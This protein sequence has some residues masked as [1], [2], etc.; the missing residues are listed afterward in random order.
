MHRD[1]CGLVLAAGAGRRLASITGHTP[2]QYWTHDG[3]ESLLESTLRRLAPVVPASRTCAVVDRTHRRFLRAP[4]R[5]PRCAAVAFQPGDRGTAAGVL[6][7]LVQLVE[8]YGAHAIVV[9]TP[10]DHGIRRDDLFRDGLERAIADVRRGAEDIVLFGVAPDSASCDYGWIRPGLTPAPWR[11]LTSVEGFV[12]KPPAAIA[13]RLLASGAVWNTM[14]LVARVGALLERYR[15]HLPDLYEAFADFGRTRAR[16]G[17]D[18]TEALYQALPT[19]D[20]S[21]DLI[22]PSGDLALMVWPSTMGWSD[23]GTPE[24]LLAWHG[25]ALVEPRPIVADCDGPR[26]LLPVLV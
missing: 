4:G 18:Y 8:A 6:F 19:Y 3:G 22:A 12:E 2:K 7:G 15:A 13:A 1:A 17:S 26:E 5:A 24:R 9:M 23:L 14:V 20:F 16:H 10:S 11:P 21:R 25:G